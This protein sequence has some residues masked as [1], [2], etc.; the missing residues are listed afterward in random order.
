M[1]QKIYNWNTCQYLR[2]IFELILLIGTHIMYKKK[3][4]FKYELATY[5]K[6]ISISHDI[7]T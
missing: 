2:N 5:T 4:L 1:N 6:Y 7:G 3:V